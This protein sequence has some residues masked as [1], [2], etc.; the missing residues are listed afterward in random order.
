VSEA[1]NIGMGL[2]FCRQPK[3]RSVNLEHDW[4]Y[5]V[6]LRSSNTA[7]VNLVTIQAERLV[8]AVTS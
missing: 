4:N 2:W 1:D 6:N 5:F 3:G 8:I 7:A